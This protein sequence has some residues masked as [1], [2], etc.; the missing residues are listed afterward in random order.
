MARHGTRWPGPADCQA[1]IILLRCD[2]MKINLMCDP[3]TGLRQGMRAPC[4]WIDLL[5]AVLVGCA[6]MAAQAETHALL[7]GVSEYPLLK[8]VRLAG[9]A[10]DLRLMQSLLPS[11]G[12]PQANTLTLSEAAGPTDW[13]TRA[14]ILS[15]MEAMSHRVKPG[16]WVVLYL[17]GHGAQVPQR[18]GMRAVYQEPD[19]LDEVFLPRDTRTW[20]PARQV[21]EGAIS[22]DEMGAA[23]QRIVRRG[24]HAWVIV[25][26]CHAADLLRDDG[27]VPDADG[28]V[29]R[30]VPAGVLGVPL[31]GQAPP[32]GALARRITPRQPSAPGWIAFYAAQADE[33]TTEELL[34]D[35]DRPGQRTRFGVFTHQLHRLA[36]HWRG[37]FA[38]L[39][40]QLQQS[41]ADRP[42]PTPRFEG[43]LQTRPPFSASTQA[44]R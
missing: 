24:A 16:D 22:D 20:D 5:L 2:E 42:F 23:V 44:A 27:G 19:G 38:D 43:P 10:N 6:T 25:D 35:P 4:P 13:P 8:G 40:G 15:A 30:R 36:M 37:S 28:P 39:A 32:R 14:R 33:Q 1:G 18:R 31:Q 41:Y 9:P 11:L 29:V 7:V 3:R 12:V 26:A 21:V 34:P 17:S